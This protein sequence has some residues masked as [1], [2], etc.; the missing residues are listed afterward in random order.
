VAFRVRYQLDR[1]VV[2]ARI[3]GQRS[4]GELRQLLVIAARQICA[5]LPDVLLDDVRIVEE[6]FSR[7]TYV[8]SPTFLSLVSSH[9]DVPSF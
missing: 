7:R 4:G 1:N 5:N 2:D 9:L 8:Y 6:P 3:L